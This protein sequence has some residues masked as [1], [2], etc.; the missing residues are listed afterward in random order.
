MPSHLI[1]VSPHSP[2][3]S[4]EINIEKR[5]VRGSLIRKKKETASGRARISLLNR[6]TEKQKEGQEESVKGGEGEERK[7]RKND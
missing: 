6:A 5:L 4:K 2:R 3:V 1:T 7:S